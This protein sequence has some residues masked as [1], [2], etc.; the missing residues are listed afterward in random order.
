MIWH[1]FFMTQ[2]PILPFSHLQHTANWADI[3][4][5]HPPFPLGCNLITFAY[6]AVYLCIIWHFKTLYH[7]IMCHSALCTV[8]CHYFESQMNN[9]WNTI[10]LHGF[11]L[12]TLYV[13]PYVK[14]VSNMPIFTSNGSYNKLKLKKLKI[15]G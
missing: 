1:C 6:F 13:K 7:R 11:I 4:P 14:E 12:D 15:D 3:H 8:L 2:S 9:C 5:Y 10:F